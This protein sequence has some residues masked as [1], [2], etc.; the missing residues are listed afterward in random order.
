MP[1]GGDNRADAGEWRPVDGG[2][3]DGDDDLPGGADPEVPGFP[4]DPGAELGAESPGGADDREV[5]PVEVGETGDATPPVGLEHSAAAL[6]QGG[7]GG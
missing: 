4:D 1:R 6:A 5:G 7:G 3:S 2:P